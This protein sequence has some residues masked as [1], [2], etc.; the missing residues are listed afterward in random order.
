MEKDRLLHAETRRLVKLYMY[1]ITRHGPVLQSSCSEVLIGD[2]TVY[3]EQVLGKIV[4]VYTERRPRTSTRGLHFLHENAPAHKPAVVANFLQEIN[5][6][7]YF[8][9]LLCN[10]KV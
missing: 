4:K 10:I 8:R 7:G 9:L 1:S 5:L 6:N 2:W 3:K